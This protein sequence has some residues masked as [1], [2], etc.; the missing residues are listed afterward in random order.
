MVEESVNSQNLNILVNLSAACQGCGFYRV[1][2]AEILKELFPDENMGN[3]VAV[4][5][6]VSGTMPGTRQLNIKGSINGRP[7]NSTE[8]LKDQSVN[9]VLCSREPKKLSSAS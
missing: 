8:E 2:L 1:K 3:G 6:C 9:A 4:V 5:E 7:F